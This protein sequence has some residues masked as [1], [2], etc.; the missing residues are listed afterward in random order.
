VVLVHSI[1]SGVLGLARY[2]EGDTPI[3]SWVGQLRERHVPDDVQALTA[4]YRRVIVLKV[5]EVAEPAPE[6]AWLREHAL[7]THEVAIGEAGISYFVPAGGEALF[8]ARNCV[9]H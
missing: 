2:L 5:H 7:L 3:I 8:A 4:G 1:P 9:C 6:E